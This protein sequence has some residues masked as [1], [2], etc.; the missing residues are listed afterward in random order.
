MICGP[1]IICS[2][3]IFVFGKLHDLEWTCKY[4]YLVVLFAIGIVVPI[5]GI[6]LF[7]YVVFKNN[8]AVHFHYFPFG[9][10]N[11]NKYKS[12]IDDNWN[13]DAFVSEV[14]DVE[15]VKLTEEEK[16]I[17][18][19]YKHWFNKY[20]KINLKYGSSKYIYVGNYS[21]FQIK[22]IIRLLISNKVH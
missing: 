18:V 15:I 10:A 6:L 1:L 21:N 19:F 12:N 8:E 14:K 11:W 16:K 3:S 22:K 20:L 5:A 4:W 17:K 7:R 13:R 2:T 9:F